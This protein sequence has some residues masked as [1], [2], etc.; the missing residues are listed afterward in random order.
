MRQPDVTVE[1]HGSVVL[2]R[3]CTRHATAWLTANVHAEPWQWYGGALA[4]E[5]RCV[6]PLVEALSL[7]GLTVNVD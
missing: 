1:H 6:S 3:P 5:P 4:V 2:V 7:D